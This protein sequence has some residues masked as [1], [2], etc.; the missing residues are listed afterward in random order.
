M[1]RAKQTFG[2]GNIINLSGITFRR[3]V[4]L[5]DKMNFQ[6]ETVMYD[7]TGDYGFDGYGE[8]RR[9]GYIAFASKNRRDVE[10]WTNGASAVM[11]MLNEW[12]K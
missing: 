4:R 3:P 2:W 11:S 12:S 5:V 10:L 6:G 1:K 7:I 9:H 8:V